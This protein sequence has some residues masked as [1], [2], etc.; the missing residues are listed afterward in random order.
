MNDQQLRRRASYQAV[1]D[2]FDAH[3]D[4]WSAKVPAVEA[5]GRWR[6]LLARVAALETIQARDTTGKTRT[7]EQQVEHVVDLAMSLCGRLRAY[8]RLRDDAE[9]LPIVDVNETELRTM[10]DADRASKLADVTAAARARLDAL[11]P[12]FEVTVDELD[13]LDADAA[14]VL[15]KVG[16]R[17]SAEDERAVAT[18]RLRLLFPEFPKLREVL[19]DLVDHLLGNADFRDGYYQARKVDD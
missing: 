15:L 1:L 12:D 14:T 16:D 9:L 11:N 8:A 4:V 2:H 17:D 6:A 7:R 10:N 13:A 19:D 3:P 18:E 5:V